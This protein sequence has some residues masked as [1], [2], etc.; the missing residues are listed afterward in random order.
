MKNLQNDFLRTLTL[1]RLSDFFIHLLLSADLFQKLLSGSNSLDPD[2]APHSVRTDLSPN[3]L[4]QS[5]DKLS[6]A[7]KGV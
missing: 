5:S 2:Q 4:Q 6:L 7:G 3:C 1:C